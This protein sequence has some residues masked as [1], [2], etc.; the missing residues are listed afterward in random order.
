MPF[1]YKLTFSNGKSFIGSSLKPLAARLKRNRYDAKAGKLGYLGAAYR[2]MG[3]PRCQ[4][5]SHHPF[6]ELPRAKAAAIREHNTR[7]PSGL[8]STDGASDNWYNNCLSKRSAPIP[9]KPLTP[10]ERRAQFIERNG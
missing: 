7:H 10:S 4:V 1:I 8:N 9:S 2:A 6:D 5:L 3:E